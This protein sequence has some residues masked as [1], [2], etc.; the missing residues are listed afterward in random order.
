MSDTWRST[1]GSRS[2]I[3]PPVAGFGGVPHRV[4]ERAFSF[5]PPGRSPM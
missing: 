3:E 5:V 2:V 1:S 4:G